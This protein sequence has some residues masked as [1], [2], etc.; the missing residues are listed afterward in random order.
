MPK[1]FVDL[2]DLT[3]MKSSLQLAELQYQISICLTDLQNFLF[4]QTEPALQNQAEKLMKQREELSK[5]IILSLAFSGQFSAGKSTIISAL[6]GNQEIKISADVATDQV[7]GYAWRGIELWDTPGLYANRA[8][9]DA[10]AG[11]ALR[12]ADLVV[13]CITTNLFDEV[14]AHDFRKLA[15]I[16]GYAGKIFL[17]INKLSMEDV[18]NT[19]QYISNLTG[20]INCTLNPYQLSNFPNSFIDAQDYREGITTQNSELVLFS[21]FEEFI[22][23]LNY[24]VNQRGLLSRLDPPI[25]LG[26]NIIEESFQTLP[27]QNFSQNPDLFLVKQQ[28]RIVENQRR[29]TDEDIKR[30]G[31]VATQKI[32]LLAEQFI[33]GELGVDP[34]TAE[35]IFS[36]KCSEINENSFGELNN[37]L[38]RSYQQLIDKLE[39][40]ANESFVADYYATTAVS[41]KT[42]IPNNN[43]NRA[44]DENPVT[45]VLKGLLGQKNSVLLKSGVVQQGFFYGAKEVAGGGIHKVIYEGG[46]LLGVKFKPWGAVQIA[47]N[48]GNAMALVGV[49][50]AAYDVYESVNESI[51]AENTERQQQQQLKEFRD[52]ISKYANNIADQI[53]NTYK[54]EFDQQIIGEIVDSLSVVRDELLAKELKNK[55]LVDQLSIYRKQLIHLLGE[56]Y[57]PINS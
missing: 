13:Y 27:E 21:R 47:K 39:K 18:S 8:D 40:F 37:A 29:R 43:R 2:T 53:F 48:V 28:I 57:V 44:R 11:Q 9:H 17:V 24:W 14:T 10:K 26:L 38:Q 15:F 50:L 22:D 30:I 46:Q 20:S 35:D 1:F 55:V 33:S 45:N 12:E 3:F 31:Q 4:S 52:S 7:S 6:T 42:K 16:Q 56:L 54:C 34:N 36:Q 41:P 23:G 49:V 19:D 25:R 51:E 5:R 32:R